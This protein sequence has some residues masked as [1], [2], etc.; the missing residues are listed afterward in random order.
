MLSKVLASGWRFSVGNFL[1]SGFKFSHINIPNWQWDLKYSKTDL[2]NEWV[3]PWTTNRIPTKFVLMDAIDN[4]H[5][6]Q[7]FWHKYV[8]PGH[9]NLNKPLYTTKSSTTI[10]IL[11]ISVCI[12]RYS[13]GVFVCALQS[14]VKVNFRISLCAG[15]RQC[16]GTPGMIEKGQAIHN[17]LAGYLQVIASEIILEMQCGKLIWK[18][19]Y[20]TLCKRFML[21][22]GG[23]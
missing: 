17:W 2:L 3:A 16:V 12:L 1:L 15:I 8:P 13:A 6:N 4:N 18:F 11:Y 19:V 21:L 14:T 20:H 23:L 10:Y 9:S 7:L 22:E 5:P